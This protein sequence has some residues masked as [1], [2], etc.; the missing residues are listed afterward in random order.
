MSRAMTDAMSVLLLVLGIAAFAAFAVRR[1]HLRMRRPVSGR[2]TGCGYSLGGLDVFAL[3]PECG[4]RHLPIRCRSCGCVLEGLD[5]VAV[6]PECGQS[7]NRRPRVSRSVYLCFLAPGVIGGLVSPLL[8]PVPFSP[9]PW[10]I[11]FGAFA[12]L[13]RVLDGVVPARYARSLAIA[14]LVPHVLVFLLVLWSSRGLLIDRIPVVG[15][16]LG[17]L[18]FAIGCAF[19]AIRPREDRQPA[20]AE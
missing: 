5:H 13:I 6:C 20:S 12:G 2:C 8:L 3:C 18:T 11:D 10:I 19:A 17:A 9:I 14:A 15:G 1:R 4:L 7:R 16:V